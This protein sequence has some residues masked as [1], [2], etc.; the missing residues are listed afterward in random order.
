MKHPTQQ[1]VDG[2]GEH[3]QPSYRI[4]EQ[5]LRCHKL[6]DERG[7]QS[8]RQDNRGNS[9]REDEGHRNQDAPI[10]KRTGKVG[11]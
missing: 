8:N 1:H 9:S 5:M 2:Q 7:T 11:R 3:E 6:A 10:L 4:D